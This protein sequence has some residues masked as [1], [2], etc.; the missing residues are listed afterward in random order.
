VIDFDQA[1][2]WQALEERLAQ[3]ESPRQRALIQNVIDHA[4]AEAAGDIDG[5]MR[6]LVA[7]PRYYFWSARGDT[8]P[9]GYDGVRSYYEAF[10][11][12]G[13]AILQSRK[14]RIA[15]DDHTIIHEGVISTLASWEIAKQRGYATPEERGH[16]LLHMRSVIL[17]SFDDAGLAYGEDSYSA[18]MPDDFQQLA[19]DELP[20]VYVDY[21][22]SLSTPV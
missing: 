21:L 6:T 1:V 2:G 4:Q 8:G 18:I 5:L 15:V 16:Y 7:D 11:R 3:T 14:D 19:D 10:V 13:A 17:W 22:A 20:Q 9:K 12:S